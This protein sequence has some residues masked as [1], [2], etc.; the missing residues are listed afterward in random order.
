MTG[1]VR[2]AYDQLIAANELKP[3][4]AQARAVAALDRLPGSEGAGGLFARLFRSTTSG[5][6]G[7]YLWAGRDG[8]AYM[9]GLEWIAILAFIA[10][11]ARAPETEPVPAAH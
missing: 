3:D 2:A 1:A 10:L 11:S 4:A 8:M 6:A 9:G 7:V 5:P